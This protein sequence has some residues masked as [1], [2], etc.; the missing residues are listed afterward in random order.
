MA[1]NFSSVSINSKPDLIFLRNEKNLFRFRHFLNSCSPPA[2]SSVAAV[3]EG[4]EGGF[5]EDSL[6]YLLWHL[7]FSFSIV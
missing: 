7:M 6:T 5:T 4:T 1:L 3:S 2:S